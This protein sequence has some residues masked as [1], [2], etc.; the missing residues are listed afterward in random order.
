M[1][2]FYY[3]IYILLYTVSKCC[4]ATVCCMSCIF[5]LLFLF[6]F[7][8]VPFNLLLDV[9]Q[10]GDACHNPPRRRILR[11]QLR[12]EDISGPPLACAIT[13]ALVAF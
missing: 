9:G 11:L 5:L 10:H 8:E 3:G 12:N 1:I 13:R 2:Y 4:T 6:L 7:C